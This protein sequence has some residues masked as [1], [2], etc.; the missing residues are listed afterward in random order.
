M[1]SIDTGLT[2]R[3]IVR[4]KEYVSHAVDVFDGMM[5]GMRAGR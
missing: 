2:I 1:V 4:A 5:V 3:G